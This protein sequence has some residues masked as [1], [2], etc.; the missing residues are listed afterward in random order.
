MTGMVTFNDL[1]GEGQ[2]VINGSNITTGTIDAD[3]VN[4]I[5]VV[6]ES[7]AAENITGTTISGKTISGGEIDGA[8]ITSKSGNYISQIASGIIKTTLIQLIS[9]SNGGFVPGITKLN[10]TESTVTNGIYL[11]DAETTIVRPVHV[12]LGSGGSAT[13]YPYV[14]ILSEGR[15]YS[16]GAI[17]PD[18]SNEHSCGTS[19][20]KWTQVYATKSAI[21]TSDKNKKHD[22]NEVSEIYEKI[23]FATRPVTYMLNGG[24]RVHIGAISQEIEQSMNDLGI[25]PEMFSAFCKDVKKTTVKNENGEC[26]E[27]PLLDEDGNVQ[28]EYGLRYGEYIMLNTHMIQKAYE[29]IE[30]QQSE[31][32]ELKKSVSFLMQKLG[33]KVDE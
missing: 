14:G 9:P 33:G 6:A 31:I 26:I 11:K 3:K 2:T 18:G 17:C 4:V 7:V 29:R 25:A 13:N 32:D 20:Y 24:D 21:N 16:D 23:F 1:K 27:A 5:N 28:Y 19:E 10:S 8:V 22:I 30:S 12:T 15:I